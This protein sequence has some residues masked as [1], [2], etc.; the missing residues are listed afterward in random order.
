LAN[1]LLAWGTSTHGF[2][3]STG[4]GFQITE[5]P[6]LP[7]TL[8]TAELNRDVMECQFIQILGSGKFGLCK[9]CENNGLGANAQ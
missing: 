3:F 5:T 1:G 6:F 7:A 4:P 2:P 9:G 8:S